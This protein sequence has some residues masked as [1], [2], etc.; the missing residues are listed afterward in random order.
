MSLRHEV[1][2]TCDAAE[3][4]DAAIGPC[5]TADEARDA[6]EAAR[7]LHFRFSTTHSGRVHTVDDTW[8]CPEHR[9]AR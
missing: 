7:W 2:I 3:G 5:A 8:R 1:R 9:A 6:A 4:C